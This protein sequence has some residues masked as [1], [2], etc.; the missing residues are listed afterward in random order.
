MAGRGVALA[1]GSSAG[2]ELRQ[3]GSASGTGLEEL[4]RRLGTAPIWRATGG[5]VGR[6]LRGAPPWM[7]SRR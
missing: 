7:C 5:C 1:A 3:L 2:Q 4:H 6:D